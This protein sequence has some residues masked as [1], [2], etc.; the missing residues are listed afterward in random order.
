MHNL[1]GIMYNSLFRVNFN[2]SRISVTN[3]LDLKLTE[4]KNSHDLGLSLSTF[5]N[6]M[7]ETQLTPTDN[8]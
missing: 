4:I 7:M 1:Q 6:E 8:C 5:I 2:I 3:I